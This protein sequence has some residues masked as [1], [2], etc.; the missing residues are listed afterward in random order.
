M[1]GG[2]KMTK[3][4]ENKNKKRRE[5]VEI[6]NADKTPLTSRKLVVT[7]GKIIFQQVPREWDH[8]IRV[9]ERVMAEAQVL[10]EIEQYLNDKVAVDIYRKFGVGIRVHING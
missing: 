10:I 4:K 3:G 6:T 9:S 7:N 5:M 2:R 8:D 1:K